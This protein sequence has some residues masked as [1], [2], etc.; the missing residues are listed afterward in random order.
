MHGFPET[1]TRLN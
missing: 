1:N